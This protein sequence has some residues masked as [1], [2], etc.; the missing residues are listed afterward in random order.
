MATKRSKMS[1]VIFEDRQ[2]ISSYKGLCVCVCVCVL[3]NEKC[4]S[5][6]YTVMKTYLK[7]MSVLIYV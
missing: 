4:K 7:M 2:N 6:I 3:P 1:S 5:R